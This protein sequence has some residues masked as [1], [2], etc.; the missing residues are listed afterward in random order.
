M[1][2]SFNNQSDKEIYANFHIQ[3]YT[4]SVVGDKIPIFPAA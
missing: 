2:W 1:L 3:D 4:N